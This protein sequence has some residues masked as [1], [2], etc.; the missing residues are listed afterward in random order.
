MKRAN[1]LLD[2]PDAV[3][4]E[5]Y[6]D[7]LYRAGDRAGALE[8]WKKATKVLDEETDALTPEQEGVLQRC[9]VKAAAGAG[10]GPIE[11]APTASEQA[12][13]N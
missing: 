6:G 12:S 4:T 3:I 5:H 2:A 9:R 13:R 7:A 1:E 11:T 8:Q 10:S